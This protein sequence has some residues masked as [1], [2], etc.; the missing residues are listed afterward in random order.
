[1]TLT[2]R[3]LAVCKACR[4][5]RG[6]WEAKRRLQPSSVMLCSHSLR[7]GGAGVEQKAPGCIGS[8]KAMRILHDCLPRETGRWGADG[9]MAAPY[10]PPPQPL[11]GPPSCVL[12]RSQGVLTRPD[13]WGL[14]CVDTFK[15]TAEQF[16][17]TYLSEPRFNRWVRVLMVRIPSPAWNDLWG[18]RTALRECW[19]PHQR[20][21][22]WRRQQ[23]MIL[24]CQAVSQLANGGFLSPVP[25]TS[26]SWHSSVRW[27]FPRR[28]HL[29]G[30][31]D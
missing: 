15:V 6:G 3:R 17:Y 1:M 14:A 19:I 9:L 4:G 22:W 26:V 10:N 27:A 2:Q 11:P 5:L 31:S 16:P 29:S 21:I 25:P 13:Q 28:P 7:Q 18:G 30:S 12:T 8:W 24:A 20:F 23:W